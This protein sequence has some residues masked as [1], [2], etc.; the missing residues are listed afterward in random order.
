[1]DHTLTD[2]QLKA[3]AEVGRECLLAKDGE[4]ALTIFSGLVALAPTRASFHLGLGLAHELAGNLDSAREQ[5]D[6]ALV[7]SPNFREALLARGSIRLALGD[8]RGR[9]DL[10]QARQLAA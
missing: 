1:M 7:Y 10:E 8:Q 3:I 5:L 9:H 2:D 4:R 6:A